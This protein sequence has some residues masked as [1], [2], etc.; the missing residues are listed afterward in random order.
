MRDFPHACNATIRAIAAR[1]T[2]RL[3]GIKAYEF[4]CVSGTRHAAEIYPF[5]GNRVTE[6]N[7]TDPATVTRHED[8]RLGPCVPSQRKWSKPR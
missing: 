3:L 4:D 5:R 7:R 2:R 1:R 8:E 6:L